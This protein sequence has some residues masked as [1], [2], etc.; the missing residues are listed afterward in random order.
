MKTRNGFISNSSS[1][2]FIV[3]AE[4]SPFY[5]SDYGKKWP[6][7]SKAKVKKLLDNGFWY[8]KVI[9]P[10]KIEFNDNSFEPG[11]G[12]GPS[13]PWWALNSPPKGDDKKY[14]GVL[15]G[16]YVSC[17]QHEVIDF[18]VKNKIS[19]IASEHYGHNSLF[20]KAGEDFYTMIENTGTLFC[21]SI[22]PTEENIKD[23]F[24]PKEIVRKIK[25]EKPKR[26]KKK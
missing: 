8:S 25:I 17:N 23:N 12:D 6:K 5:G 16:K 3:Q 4:P 21:Q 20:Y 18:L 14:N 26:R 15:L 13:V 19:F 10:F 11:C 24:K 1:S 9:D 2:S 22:W 7:L